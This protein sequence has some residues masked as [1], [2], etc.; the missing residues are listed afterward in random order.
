MGLFKAS[1][2]LFKDGS[3]IL[4]KAT[5]PSEYIMHPVLCLTLHF[6]E[7]LFYWRSEQVFYVVTYYNIGKVIV[8]V[9]RHNP[10]V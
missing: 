7:R 8:V 4:S 2:G 1:L 5:V 10:N 9:S 6:V 3:K